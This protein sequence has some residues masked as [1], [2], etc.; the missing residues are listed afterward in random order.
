MTNFTIIILV[1]ISCNNFAQNISN[2]YND[3]G[4]LLLDTNY[5]ITQSQLLKWSKNET[6]LLLRIS[7]NIIYPQI[8]RESG[9]TGYAIVSFNCDSSMTITN[10]TIQFESNEL[11]GK[12]SLD[13]IIKFENTLV[14]FLRNNSG[15]PQIYYIPIVF[16]L[17]DF[18]DKIKN[19]KAL[20]IIKENAPLISIDID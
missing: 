5:R 3:K 10:L 8:Y 14:N 18:G 17:Y 2:I 11:F 15:I 9:I 4:Q 12:A 16:T 1:F 6:P 7:Q 20:P 19:Y 13:A